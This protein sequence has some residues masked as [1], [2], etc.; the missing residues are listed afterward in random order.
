MRWCCPREIVPAA[1]PSVDPKYPSVSTGLVLQIPAG[2]ARLA[3]AALTWPGLAQVVPLSSQEATRDPAGLPPLW[4]C[5]VL[6]GPA[7]GDCQ[8][9]CTCRQMRCRLKLGVV[10]AY[11]LRLFTTMLSGSSHSTRVQG[12]TIHPS[13]NSNTGPSPIR[14]CWL[15]PTICLRRNNTAVLDL[16]VLT[17]IPLPVPS[18]ALPMPVL[19][20][21]DCVYWTRHSCA[22]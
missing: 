21:T 3:G 6:G 20:Q 22:C 18:P 9:D 10:A 16:P 15:W 14:V 7:A 17:R 13:H 12:P 5:P 1:F 4:P 11:L 2:R 19:S 8:W